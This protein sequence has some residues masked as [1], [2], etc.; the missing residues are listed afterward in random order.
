[1][2]FKRIS[3]SDA[4]TAYIVV[5]NVSG[6]TMT[7]GYHAFFDITTSADG[8]RVT[9]ATTGSLQAYAG[10]IDAAIANNGYGLCQVYGYRSAGF[11]YGSGTTASGDALLPVNG[12]WAMQATTEATTSGFKSWGFM[13]ETVGSTA[14]STSANKRIF[15]RAL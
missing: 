12:S 1:M 13:C 11:T 6:S 3:R 7:A 5:Q 4:E 8:V 14:A 2:L 15:I 9:M 10:C